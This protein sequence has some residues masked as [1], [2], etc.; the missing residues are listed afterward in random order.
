MLLQEKCDD[1][2][3]YNKACKCQGKSIAICIVIID[4]STMQGS[5]QRKQTFTG[6][7]NRIDCS[8]GL[9]VTAL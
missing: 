8:S 2:L 3:R 4:T 9:D 5:I 6:K 7:S 1:S